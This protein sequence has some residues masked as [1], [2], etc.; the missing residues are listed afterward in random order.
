MFSENTLCEI[1]DTYYF[2]YLFNDSYKSP[3]VILPRGMEFKEEDGKAVGLEVSVYGVREHAETLS[4]KEVKKLLALLSV[5]LD[6]D[7]EANLDR[8]YRI[9]DD[10]SKEVFVRI[11]ETILLTGEIIGPEEPKI[12]LVT[13]MGSSDDQFWRQISHFRNG[14]MSSDP[15]EKYREFF[16]VLEDEGTGYTQDEQS[17]RHAVNHPKLTHPIHSVRVNTILGKPFYDPLDPHHKEIIRQYASKLYQKANTI[18]ITK[19]KS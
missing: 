8:S 4:D 3:R 12:D 18:L 13:P 1:E 14:V 19:I 2:T 5:I 7:I 17:L 11:H 15:I 10:G 16:L 9:K 6:S